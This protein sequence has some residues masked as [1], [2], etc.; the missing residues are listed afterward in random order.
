MAEF[1]G[2]TPWQ[3]MSKASW[4]EKAKVLWFFQTVVLST[5]FLDKFNDFGL[6]HRRMC[7]FLD[8]KTNPSDKKFISVFRGAY[9][10]TVLLGFCLWLFCW[11]YIT[12]KP[13]SIAYNTASKENA[14]NFSDD[15]REALKECKLLHDIFSDDLD[16]ERGKY[17]KWTKW[18]VRLQWCRFQVAS[19]DTKQVS[20]HHQIIINDDL[21]NDDN[22]YSKKERE[23]VK[24]KWKYQKSILTKYKKKKIGLE[25]DVGT[26]FHSK[27]IISYIMH[28]IETYDKF[29]LPFAVKE[30]G[31][32]GNLKRRDGY[33]T[34]PEMFTWEDFDDKLKEQGISIFNTQYCLRVL[35]EASRLCDPEWIEYFQYDPENYFRILVCDP[36]GTET[37]TNDPS[38]ITICDFGEDGKI[39]VQY[40]DQ[41]WLT[42]VRLIKKLD[43]LTTAYKPDESYIEQEKYG[44]AIKDTIEYTASKFN[45]SFVSH[46]DK[47]QEARVHQLKQWLETGRLLFRKG[48]DELINQILGYPDYEHDDLVVSLAYQLQVMDFPTS[49][50]KR[51]SEPE[52]DE[53]EKEI[54]RYEEKY[55]EEKINYDKIF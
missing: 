45:L 53:F 14:E 29:I 5:A 34:F 22:A 31:K 10:T 3:Y 23:S 6:L 44:I 43:Q 27:D 48:M 2:L 36:A 18:T 50:I 28:E 38:A 33:L 12:G 11:H 1:K 17:S 24:R 47:P 32:T 55:G 37:E 15:F 13:I 19:L 35:E 21:S 16:P 26:P 39:Y 52:E 25:I 46:K 41:Y 51:L 49:K 9:K 4:R 7:E 8:N 30:D 54:K 42:P 20:R 40:A